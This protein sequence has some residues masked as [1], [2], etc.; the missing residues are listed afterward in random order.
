MGETA[1]SF[2]FDDRSIDTADPVAFE[3]FFKPANIGSEERLMLAVLQDAVE[4]FQRY[5][6]SECP[7]EKRIFQEAERWILARNSDWVFSFENIDS[8]RRSWQEPNVQ[9][10]R[11]KFKLPISSSVRFT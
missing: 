2:P 8:D 7:W 6:L 3:Q 9:S 1:L 11:M 4:C 10:R 5:A